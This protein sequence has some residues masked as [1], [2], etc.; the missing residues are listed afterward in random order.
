MRSRGDA[1]WL[2]L[3][4]TTLSGSHTLRS[5]DCE[6]PREPVRGS[7]GLKGWPQL[8][9]LVGMQGLTPLPM[10]SHLSTAIPQPKREGNPSGGEG[11]H[12]RA[13]P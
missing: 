7:G 2:N 12:V 13:T 11:G 9:L 8:A 3:A 6:P 10:Y 5:W 1:P 4:A